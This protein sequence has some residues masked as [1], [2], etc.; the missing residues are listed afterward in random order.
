MISQPPP[1]SLPAQ[2]GHMIS[3]IQLMGLVRNCSKKI[4]HHVKKIVHRV[5]EIHRN[6]F[7]SPGVPDIPKVLCFW[8]VV[9]KLGIEKFLREVIPSVFGEDQG[10][11][12]FLSESV[13]YLYSM[14]A[15]EMLSDDPSM[16]LLRFETPY[17]I[18]ETKKIS[19]VIDQTLLNYIKNFGDYYHAVVMLTAS[20]HAARIHFTD[21]T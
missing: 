14:S 12:D 8:Q 13:Q 5:K 4:M 19:Q 3:T 16:V 9:K 7:D 1:H 6:F 20:Y 21:K 17:L 11:E 15:Q 18:S 10:L 2:R